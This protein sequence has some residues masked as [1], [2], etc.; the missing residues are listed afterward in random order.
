MKSVTVFDAFDHR[1]GTTVVQGVRIEYEQTADGQTYEFT[2]VRAN[3]HGFHETTFYFEEDEYITHMGASYGCSL[4]RI[5]FTTNKERH[6]AS[7]GKGGTYKKLHTHSEHGHHARF[8]SIGLSVGEHDAHQLFGSYALVTGEEC[9]DI[10]EEFELERQRIAAAE[11][12]RLR[13]EE[14]ERIRAEEEEAARL[15][16]EERLRLEAEERKRQ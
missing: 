5:E 7:T 12:E 16:E 10:C 13:I 15:A 1:W 4:D 3:G 8:V 6:F 9:R 14:E 11:A 2:H